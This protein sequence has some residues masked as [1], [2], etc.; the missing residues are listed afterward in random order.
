MQQSTIQCQAPSAQI[1]A[2]ERYKV[3][4]N[5]QSVF[6]YNSQG[7][8]YAMLSAEGK[9]T[10]EIEDSQAAE[11][12][13][14]RPLRHA[15]QPVQDGGVLRF[16]T[17]APLKLSVEF[18]DNIREP[19]FIW[20]NPLEREARPDP[21]DPTVRYF[22]GGEV[23]Q[24]G[25]IVL[26]DGE[27]VYIEEGAVVHGRIKAEN[28]SNIAI[29]G[30]GILDG[31]LWREAEEGSKRHLMMLLAGCKQVTIEGISII[32]GPTWHVVPAGSTQVAITN[33]NILT[34][35]GTGDG[36]DIVGC[37][38]VTVDNVFVRSKDDC[39]AIKAVD[40]FHKAGL[41]DVRNVR[42]I[43]SVFWN[44]EW[45]NALE[46]GYETRCAS[47]SE[48]EFSD[49][50]IIRCEFEGYESGGTFTIHNGD[51][52]DVHNV[53]YKN[54][55]V[56]DSREKLID[57]KVQFSQYSKDT[58]RGHVRD[59][60]FEDVAIVGGLLPVSI[61]RGYDAGHMIEQVTIRNLTY[62]GEPL[63]GANE[64]KMVV[65]L[66]KKIEFVS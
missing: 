26:A 45:G 12:V 17:E 50:D 51:R 66:S 11:Q 5:G 57:I 14:V 47:I 62:Q 30:R 43:R 39:I 8:G 27:T 61:I 1:A 46:I 36:I 15:I 16:E 63:R 54:I 3:R 55:R 34:Y 32:D 4:I 29:R 58:E 44:A 22:R 48:V 20:I 18:D 49:C 38:D 23:H 40:Y 10:V 2:S 19:L 7:A 21:A 64:A 42:V 6:V 37:E 41:H 60:R 28:A 25:E 13:V 33:I 59:I 53:L 52:A 35:A 31:S 65:E 56:E 24:A 9:V